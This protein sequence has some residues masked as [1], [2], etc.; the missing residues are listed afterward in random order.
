MKETRTGRSTLL[1][2][3]FSMIFTIFSII[4]CV[5]EYFTTSKFVQSRTIVFLRIFVESRSIGQMSASTFSRNIICKKRKIVHVVKRV[6]QIAA[7]QMDLLKPKQDTNGVMLMFLLQID[8]IQFD[9]IKTRL[10]NGISNNSLQ[11]ELKTVLGFTTSRTSLSV[12]TNQMSIESFKSN[13][14]ETRFLSCIYC[15]DCVLAKNKHN[16]ATGCAVGRVARLQ[17]VWTTEDHSHMSVIPPSITGNTRSGHAYVATLT[18]PPV[19]SASEM[20][21]REVSQIEANGNG[22]DYGAANGIELSEIAVT[23]LAQVAKLKSNTTIVNVP[24]N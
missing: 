17:S 20:S 4:S 9:Q 22:N 8:E 11:N 24:P 23:D 7:R 1:I 13:D 2:T 5:L 10:E 21:S 3:I 6:V 19:L 16:N 18:T 14:N 12:P 15:L